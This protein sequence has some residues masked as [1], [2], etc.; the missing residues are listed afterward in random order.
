VI[1]AVLFDKDGTL[2][3]SFGPWLDLETD[4]CR[5]LVDDDAVV[6]R[7]LASIGVRGR[8]I[9]PHGLLASGTVAAILGAFHRTLGTGEPLGDF[10]ARCQAFLDRRQ[11]E[12]PIRPAACPGVDGVLQALRA[13][14]LPLGVATSDSWDATVDQLA[15]L[16][17]SDAF[18]VVLTGDRCPRPKPDPWMVN[19]FSRITGVAPDQIAVVGDTPADRGMALGAGARFYGV[20]TG[21]GGRADL[22]GGAAVVE[23]A[24][25]LADLLFQEVADGLDR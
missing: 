2:V 8:Q 16:G 15:V 25:D 24:A 4:L 18:S 20:L 6:D 19:E 3:D 14:G 12:A 11:A 13:R 23:T 21:T 17:W 7:M 22:A 1:R 10:V 5:F 9:D